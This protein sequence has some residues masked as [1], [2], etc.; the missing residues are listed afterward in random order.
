MMTEP[1]QTRR[2]VQAYDRMM[3]R[4]KLRLEEL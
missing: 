1:T 3:E 4:V 2:L